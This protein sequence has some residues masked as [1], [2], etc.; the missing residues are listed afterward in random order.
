MKFES[1]L[2]RQIIGCDKEY[3]SA[4]CVVFGAPFDGTA[5]FRPGSRF[6]PSA[7][8]TESIGI[9]TYSPYQQKDLEDTAV[10]DIGDIDLPFGNT[11]RAL[12]LI[13]QTVSQII[14]DGKKPIMLGGEHLI[15][16]PA[17]H[18]VQERYG[19][20]CI[21]HFDAHADL[22]EDYLGEK[23]SHSTVMRRVYDLLGKD[24]IFQFGI[25]SGT[26]DEFAFANAGNTTMEPFTL[27]TVKKVVQ[28]IGNR[29][30]YLSVD[31]DVLDP[32]EFPGTG[33]PEAGGVRFLEL[34]EALLKLSPLSIVGADLVEL[35]PHYD[36]SG[37]STALACKLL[38]EILLL[39]Q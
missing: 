31:L 38:R 1:M 36:V 32:S 2:S 7:I 11:A 6:S 20:L 8:R 3:A 9:E 12:L 27:H 30:V 37:M 22:R 23:L 18:S 13:E 15:S 28:F 24:R 5:S 25:R 14:K 39:I 29:P 17:I 10:C 19:D 26:Q 33:T 35:A 4:D 16:L 21:L 34:L